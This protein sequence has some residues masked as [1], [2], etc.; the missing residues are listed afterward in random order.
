MGEG[1]GC[2]MAPCL[3]S[4]YKFLA[5]ESKLPTCYNPLV[6][7]ADGNEWSSFPRG[8]EVKEK[9]LFLDLK[10]N[11]SLSNI[12]QRPP[13]GWPFTGTFL[14]GRRCNRE[15]IT[16]G[17]LSITE[18][19][20]IS[21]VKIEGHFKHE[22]HHLEQPSMGKASLLPKAEIQCVPK[23]ETF[24]AASEITRGKFYSRP[25]VTI[26]TRTH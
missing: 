4:T 13:L 21:S 20:F 14:C 3:P 22:L 16:T 1:L 25:H 26:K 5:Q 15:V 19:H 24:W 12:M 23:F 8:T 17:G 10:H 9:T 2:W 6:S 18:Y 11:F 7:W